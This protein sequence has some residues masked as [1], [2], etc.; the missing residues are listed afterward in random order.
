MSKKEHYRLE[1]WEM[2]TK[3]T[4]LETDDLERARRLY[5]M[6]M[7]PGDVSV[8]LYVNGSRLKYPA[9]WSLMQWPGSGGFL[10]GKMLEGNGEWSRC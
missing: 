3:L 10:F 6:F 1:V 5:K 2:G 8:E 7:D 9:A 4:E